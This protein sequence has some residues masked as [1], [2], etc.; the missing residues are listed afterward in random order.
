MAGAFFE[1]FV[2]SEILKSYGN[3]GVLDAPLFFYRDK[4]MNE[5]DLLIEN[6]GVLHPIEIKKN[7]DPQKTDVAAFNMLDKIPNVK[8]GPGGIV[9]LYDKLAA[10]NGDDKVIPVGFL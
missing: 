7:A 3:A 1:S 10:L 2:V 6:G 8:R 5:I 9:C 4:E